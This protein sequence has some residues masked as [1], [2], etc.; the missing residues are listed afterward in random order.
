LTFRDSRRVSTN[1]GSR[2]RNSV[3]IFISELPFRV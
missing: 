2:R 3:I 1:Q